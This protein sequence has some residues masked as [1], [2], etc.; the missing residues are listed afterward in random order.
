[1]AHKI[2]E[3][4]LNNIVEET[5]KQTVNN[6]QE[7]MSYNGV[8]IEQGKKLRSMLSPVY[9]KQKECLNELRSIIESTFGMRNEELGGELEA[10]LSNMYKALRDIGYINR[11]LV[12]FSTYFDAD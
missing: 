8:D 2:S 12:G 4:L 3:Q 9:I 11:K 5:I 1:M 6:L 10:C 7:S